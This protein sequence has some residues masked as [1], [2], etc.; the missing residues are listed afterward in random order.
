MKRIIVE[1]KKNKF[2][3]CSF[4]LLLS[5]A[6]FAHGATYEVAPSFDA[7][8][9]DSRCNFQAALDA[10]LLNNGS[11]NTIRLT[12]GEYLGNFTYFPSGNNTG[13][14]EISGGWNSDFTSRILDPSNTILNGNHIG[15][16]LN[17]KLEDPE[18]TDII[19]GN[20]KLEGVT[21]K[22]GQAYIG[23]GL[24]AFTAAP[25]RIDI[26]NCIIE[27]NHADDAAG[28]CA[29]G[30]YDFT[31]TDTNGTLFME[32]NIIRNNDVSIN[33]ATDGNG[34]GCDIYVNGLTV[35]RNNLV[36]GNSVGLYN[37]QHASGGGLKVTIL[38]GDVYLINNTITNNQMIAA[39]DS[40]ANGGGISIRNILAGSQSFLLSWAPGHAYFYNNI[41]FNNTISTAQ[42]FGDDIGNQIRDASPLA[43]SSILISHSNY[44]E[45]WSG[46][47]SVVTPVLTDNMNSEPFLSP[48]GSNQFG[49]TSSS[50]C[51]DTGLNSA[52]Y[53]P[54]KDLNHNIRKLDGNKDGILTVDMGCY[55]YNSQQDVE[56]E[57]LWNLF[58]PA[59]FEGNK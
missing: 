45:L 11:S 43:G 17:L 16:A 19:G 53:L 50:P 30:V 36:H 5:M 26:T 56:S 58:F 51:I 9:S 54:E 42:N 38:A 12:Q 39:Q 24:L 41:I 44:T 13:N 10:S 18:N 8:C 47:D 35:M 46:S 15:Q 21:V 32:N 49:L 2:V 23:G 34:G 55:E 22:N 25:Y 27:D 52:P 14:L 57:F 29:V 1:S 3:I 48:T 40:D 33:N 4:F 37:Y 59:I 31:S 7:D 28:G 6:G 20:L